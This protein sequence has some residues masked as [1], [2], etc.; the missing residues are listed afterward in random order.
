MPANKQASRGPA[1]PVGQ[2]HERGVHLVG[3]TTQ[4][5]AAGIHCGSV[6]PRLT[7]WIPELLDQLREATTE[8]VR[9]QTP[10][11]DPWRASTSLLD[12]TLPEWNS[13]ENT[14]DD[15]TA[16]A[17]AY[18]QSIT[19]LALVD[20]DT[21][22]SYHTQRHNEL[23]D[24]VHTVGTGRGAVNAGLGAL[25]KGPVALHREFDHT[26]RAIT[27]ALDGSAWT[28][29]TDRRTGVRALAAIAVLAAGFDVRVV[30]SPALKRHLT[31][32]YP[33]WCEI[34]LDLTQSRDRS[35]PHP[36]RV[37]SHEPTTDECHP[38]WEALDGLERTPG[39]RRLLTNLDATTGRTY[40]DL[41]HDHAIDIEAGTVSRYVLDL[42]TRGLVDVDRR[43]THHSVTLSE[44]GQTAVAGYLDAAGDLV[45][46]EQRRLTDD[47]TATTHDVTSTVS[48]RP[49]GSTGDTP[50]SLEEW[51]AATGD[52]DADGEF[53]QWLRG[54]DTVDETHLHQRFR[55]PA[56]DDSVTLVDDTPTPFDDGRVGYLSHTSGEAQVVLQ[57]GGPLATLGRLAA[58]L[59]SDKALSK[60]LTPSRFGRTFEAIHRGDLEQDAPRVLCRGHQVGWYSED[61]HTYAAWRERITT[62]RDILLAKIGEHTSSTNSAARSELFE[63]L[64]GLVA[65]AT[66]LYHAI[67][68]DLTT[69]MR[70][71]DTEAL[72]RNSTQRRQLCTFLA[73]TVPKQ[74]VY[75]VHSGYRMLFEER[76]PKLRR[77]LPYDVEPDATMDLTMSWVLAGPTITDLRD[78]IEE[79]LTTELTAVREAIA[80]GTETAPTLSIPV[81]D[82]TTYPAIRRVIDEIAMT[83]DAQ[84]TP[85]E[86]QRLVRRCLRSFGPADTTRRACPYD[87][88]VSLLRALNESHAPTV[89]AVERAAATLSVARFRPDLVP[90]A[91]ALYAT[92][93]RADE[94]LGRSAL[95]ERADIAASSYDRRIG[96]VQALDRVQAVQIDGHRRWVTTDEP[97]H[98]SPQ[99]SPYLDQPHSWLPLLTHRSRTHSVRLAPTLWIPLG[100]D[101]RHPHRIHMWDQ[102]ALTG[103][104]VDTALPVNQWGPRR[105]DCTAITDAPTHHSHRPAAALETITDE[106]RM[107][108]QYYAPTAS[109]LDHRRLLLP[110]GV[111]R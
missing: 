105:E 69:T 24:T 58:V 107:T 85:R 38:A 95:L 40:Q 89:A 65:S 16:E 88:V 81:V 20:G 94:P 6:S 79:A 43:G 68:V 13:L 110:R 83:H 108:P 10:H 55:T 93:L 92:L 63:A 91:T 98:P 78:A 37:Q 36:H 11:T 12:T 101:W 3:P 26:P 8:T 45:H 22:S 66:H 54:P 52:P 76:P 59:L 32:R 111:S 97:S 86:R 21:E 90:T 103:T 34:H 48:P 82:G 64:H 84:W 2:G 15:A 29:L 14:W 72:A 1:Q 99:P 53:I 42:E 46:P 35:H 19:E 25:A 73:K 96:T 87:V 17:V 5:G 30:V 106:P 4:H 109:L 80:E 7:E 50:P 51:L 39:K 67:G 102:H 41:E 9:T 18:T 31:R 104:A 71:P 33:Q 57:W 60:I 47:L 27:L 28:D 62:V 23:R 75:G 74:S 77:R 44:R 49:E 70:F 100:V 56:Q 61:E